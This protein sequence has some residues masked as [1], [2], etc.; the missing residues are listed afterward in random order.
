[1]LNM[2]SHFKLVVASLVLGLT[3]TGPALAKFTAEDAANLDA[4]AEATVAQFKADTEG[5][6]EVLADAKGILVC[7]KITKAGLGFGAEGGQCVLTT[8][9]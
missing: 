7:P 2:K 8:G 4:D 6:A 5:V 9:A 3:L 1:M